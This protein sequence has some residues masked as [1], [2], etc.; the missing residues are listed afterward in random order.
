[1]GDAMSKAFEDLIGKMKIGLLPADIFISANF[2]DRN[3]LL[4]NNTLDVGEDAEL[5]VTAMN[6]GKGIGYGTNLEVASDN[7]KIAFEKNITIGDIPPGETRD[8]RIN[9]KAG[10]DIG[11]G[12]AIF[13]LN[14]KE[15]LGY[16]A[17]SVA[18]SIPTSNQ[19]NRSIDNI[20]A[21]IIS[22]MRQKGWER[23]AIA[24]IKPIDSSYAKLNSYLLEEFYTRFR[25]IKGIT[26]VEKNLIDKALIKIGSSF[27]NLIRPSSETNF[28]INRDAVKEFSKLTEADA[29]FYWVIVEA[30]GERRI[31]T[32]LVD[33]D[34]GKIF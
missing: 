2:S 28:F 24:E 11:D 30:S 20:V 7:S 33:I 12:K 9:L 21:K 23:I 5:V 22:Q 8:I 26:V 3:S 4:P 19:I 1:M 10:K 6:K 25:Q 18:L 29:I 15:K 32:Y 34:K 17:K 27:S 13:N 16:N 31:K 14:L